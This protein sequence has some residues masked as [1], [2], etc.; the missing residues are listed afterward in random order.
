MQLS[1]DLEREIEYPAPRDMRFTPT[2]FTS[3]QGKK[4]FAAKF[5]SFVSNGFREKDF[6]I[7]FY[8]RLSMCFG[9]IAHY[10][11]NG[12][13]DTWFSSKERQKDFIAHCLSWECYGDPAY[14]FSDVEKYLIGWLKE[15]LRG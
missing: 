15:Y 14:T 5:V 7:S 3:E 11:R 6:S 2:E 10:D 8:R 13:Y 9:H 12:F 4:N 1:F